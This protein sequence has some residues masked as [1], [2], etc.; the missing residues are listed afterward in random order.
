MFQSIPPQ[1]AAKLIESG[2]AL[3]VDVRELNEWTTGHIPSAQHAPLSRLRQ[4][5]KAYLQR[6]K[7]IFVCAA[8]S[9]SKLAAQL[10]TALGFKEVYNL[11]GGT[12]AWRAAG[13]EVVLPQQQAA[14]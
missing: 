13:L 14:G 8:G 3:V 1:A 12:Q 5:P 6:D 10:A 9:R 4:S 11:S 7:L 2:E